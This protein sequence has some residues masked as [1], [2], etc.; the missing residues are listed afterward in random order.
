MLHPLLTKMFHF[1]YNCAREPVEEE[2]ISIDDAIRIIQ[3]KGARNQVLTLFSSPFIENGV[4]P[5]DLVERIRG[6]FGVN[7]T[8]ITVKSQLY[9]GRKGGEK[10]HYLQLEKGNRKLVV[11]YLD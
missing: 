2:R 7:P 9:E 1:I 3:E 4:S 5:I 8:E 10:E 11:K 6:F